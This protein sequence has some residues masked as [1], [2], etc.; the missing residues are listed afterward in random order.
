MAFNYKSPLFPFVSFKLLTLAFC[1]GP[2]AMAYGTYG[3]ARWFVPALFALMSSVFF[4]LTIR[5]C[6]VEITPEGIVVRGIVRRRRLDFSQVKYSVQFCMFTPKL[7]MIVVKSRWPFSWYLY[8]ASYFVGDVCSLNPHESVEY[9]N[10]RAQA[11]G[12]E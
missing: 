1:L 10:T 7:I 12:V 9:I 5:L 11:A 3:N 6:M 8:V 4:L 2:A